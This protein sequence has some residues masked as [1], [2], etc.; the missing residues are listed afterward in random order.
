MRKDSK[1]IPGAEEL[2]EILAREAKRPLPEGKE[3]I[4]YPKFS[5]VIQLLQ[6][7]DIFPK[8]FIGDLSV[9]EVVEVAKPII[10]ELV[11]KIL[12]DPSPGR[13]QRLFDKVY[14]YLAEEDEPQKSDLIFTF[15]APTLLRVEKAV[16]LYKKGLAPI[17]FF[18]GG[19]PIYQPGGLADA[20][21]YKNFTLHEGIPPQAII[22]E[23]KSISIPDNVR[24]SLNL[25]DK[26]DLRF[27][28]MI[29]VNSPYVQRRG[30]CHFKK[31]LPDKIKIYRVNC[32]TKPDYTKGNWYKNENG[33]RV[34][35]NE[36]VK[37]KI[38]VILNTA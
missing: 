25:M 11:R 26:M 7:Y 12:Q 5:L 32:L 21:V 6:A 27:E 30:W 22:T 13:D 15:G 10:N 34:I 36:F 28:S 16:E 4:H 31:Y 33:I 2:G 17:L 24:S 8:I 35:L 38:A 20:L 29:L 9:E 3:A 37:M 19:R 23:E 1:Q 14:D 18:S